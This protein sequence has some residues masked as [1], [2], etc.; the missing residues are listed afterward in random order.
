MTDNESLFDK[1]K[2]LG[3]Q[4]GTK[5]VPQ[6]Q[7]RRRS[8]YDVDSIINGSDF[9]TVYGHTFFTVEH[10]PSDY[11]HGLIPLCCER[12]MDVLA[13]WGNTPRITR[14]GG[15]NVLFLDTETSGLFGGTGT[16]VFLIGLGYRTEDGFELVQFFMRDPAQEPAMLAALDQ[17]LARF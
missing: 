15:R 9:S 10:Y 6:L 2:S 3:V 5:N 8:P 17:W 13:S 7:Q 12:E 4:V 16:Y 1:L 11:C 14:P